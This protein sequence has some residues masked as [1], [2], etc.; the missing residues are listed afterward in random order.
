MICRSHLTGIQSESTCKNR[1][2][3]T[4]SQCFL[5][6]VSAWSLTLKSDIWRSRKRSH[7]CC[8]LNR[9]PNAGTGLQPPSSRK[10]LG[11]DAWGVV[12]DI[13]ME[14][15]MDKLFV[16]SQ[17]F[18][19][20]SWLRTNQHGCYWKNRQTKPANRNNFCVFRLTCIFTWCPVWQ[21]NCWK[22]CMCQTLCDCLAPV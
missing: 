2:E 18:C 1:I 6:Q 3:N 15:C 19:A 17:P 13:T 14:A 12:S 10:V 5:S 21:G 4:P 22:L 7:Q 8:H 20:P 9:D 11:S 16:T